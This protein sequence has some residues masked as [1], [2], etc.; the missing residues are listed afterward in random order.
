M[1]FRKHRIA[2]LLV[3]TPYGIP[4]P[5]VLVLLAASLVATAHVMAATLTDQMRNISQV[6]SGLI[7]G[8][9]ARRV[10]VEAQGETLLLKEMVNTLVDCAHAR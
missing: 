8:S 6:T 10:T 1:I 5:C 7:D 3:G 4:T 9:L 2:S